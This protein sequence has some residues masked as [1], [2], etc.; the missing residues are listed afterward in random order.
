MLF[1]VFAFAQNTPRIA[2]VG[3]GPSGMSTAHYL[4]QAGY[5]D[6][7]VLEKNSSVGGKSNTVT[8]DGQ[9]YEM[10]SIMLGPSYVEVIALAKEYNQPIV[11]FAKGSTGM[12]EYSPTDSRMGPLTTI[13]KVKYLAAAAEYHWIYN[14]YKKYLQ[15]PGMDKVPLELSMPF[16]EW[17]KK[18]AHMSNSLVELLSHSFVS[19]GYGYMSEVPAAYV[20]RYFSPQLL[21][22]FIFGQVSMFKKG[23]Q[24][25]WKAIAQKEK[26]HTNFDVSHA[27]KENGVWKVQ[28][29]NGE[30][31]EFDSIIWTGSLEQAAEAMKLP[32]PLENV[33]K[34][35]K[36]EQYYSTLVEFEKLP[37][38]SGVIT[39]NYQA[40]RQGGIVSW[41][42]RWP[43]ESDVANI[44]TLAND[45]LT[46]EKVEEQI[47]EFAKLNGF[48]A[49][50]II[51]NVGWKYFPHFN[52]E[53]FAS[54][55]YKTIEH[56]QGKDGLYFGGELLNFST[57]EHSVAYAK[58]LVSRFSK[59]NPTQNKSEKSDKPR[60][61]EKA[62][63]VNACKALF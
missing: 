49:K 51:K 33:F 55:A 10:G 7:T 40:S 44:Y 26:V 39:E 62:V 58:S 16:T 57:V 19:F 28:S 32:K 50:K 47:L 8:H 61:T 27:V 9:N 46:P 23:Y 1:G 45:E 22:S 41:L 60:L 52:Q 31:L 6:V 17:A 5:T 29:Q 11:S 54:G 25:L 36:Y 21:R 3:G 42:H 30:V 48:K 18:N 20:L 35:I 14:K 12:V 53:T 13:Q 34:S 37:H 63:H 24:E 38:G 59:E 4:R 2:I 43:S 15:E 56:Y